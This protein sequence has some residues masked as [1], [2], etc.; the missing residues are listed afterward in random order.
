MIRELLCAICMLSW[1]IFGAA[2]YLGLAAGD[3]ARDAR[4]LAFW[5]AYDRKMRI[6]LRTPIESPEYKRLEQELS[7]L[8]PPS[9]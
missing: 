5:Q 2:I 7:N 8:H 6:V 1:L 4:T 3:R 9:D